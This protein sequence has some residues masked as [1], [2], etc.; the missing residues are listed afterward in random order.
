MPLESPSNW[1]QTVDV[2]AEASGGC[3]LTTRISREKPAKQV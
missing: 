1:Q 3:S 2:D